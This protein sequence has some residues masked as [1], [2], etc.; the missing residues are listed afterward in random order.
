M[1]LPR[2]PLIRKRRPTTV[3]SFVRQS[4]PCIEDRQRFGI[5]SARLV[6][7]ERDGYVAI[8]LRRD[9]PC[10]F[11]FAQRKD[12]ISKPPPTK[13]RRSRMLSGSLI[14]ARHL[15]RNGSSRRSVT[16]TFGSSRRSVTATLEPSPLDQWLQDREILTAKQDGSAMFTKI[17]DALDALKAGQVVEVL[18]EGPYRETLY[19]VLPQDT[20]LITRVA[21]HVVLPE[22]SELPNAST[23]KY[24]GHSL[25]G[26]FRL[27]GFIFSARQQNAAILMNVGGGDLTIEDC[28]FPNVSTDQASQ[29]SLNYGTGHKTASNV[30]R[31]CVFGGDVYAGFYGEGTSTFVLRNH[32]RAF[33]PAF[34]ASCFEGRGD[35]HTLAIRENIFDES[36]A[37]AI[38]LGVFDGSF[39]LRVAIEE[40]TV[41]SGAEFMR[42]NHG[43]PEVPLIIRDNLIASPQGILL[44]SGAENSRA[45]AEERIVR[46]GNCYFQAST[47]PDGLAISA[48]D[49]LAQP[50]FLSRA[51]AAADYARLQ[52]DEANPIWSG[53][54][55]PGPAPLQGDWFTR[56]QE[57]WKVAITL[58]RDEPGT[59]PAVPGT[60]PDNSSNSTPR[61]S[62]RRSVTATLGTAIL[63]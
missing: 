13:F 46:A 44:A 24:R 5:N 43:V 31:D 51:P 22:W 59:P 49:I 40:N 34:G 35:P 2:R 6:T 3:P 61:G 23:H 1:S 50:T 20:G 38:N 25:D 28:V 58:R 7:A 33:T 30:I 10:T 36:C 57:R 37:R 19:K 56:L 54:L 12:V 45:L 21:S 62:S 18:D 42:A 32:F 26:Q 63:P 11:D 4:F 52:Q 41:L 14:S 27:S 60:T 9:E 53:A 29:R 8:T 55:P 39:N 16:A 15:Y 47:H 17:Q 48:S